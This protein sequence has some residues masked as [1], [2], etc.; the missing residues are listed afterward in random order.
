MA[1][2]RPDKSKRHEVGQEEQ[3]EQ[4]HMAV[5][6]TALSASISVAVKQA[7]V[8]ALGEKT[9]T[10]QST[11]PASATEQSVV[12][13]VVNVS[14]AGITQEKKANDTPQLMK[15]CEIVRDIAAKPGDWLY[16]DEQFRFIRQSAP[17]QYP[18]DAIHWELWLKA[19]TNFRPK[20]QFP[21]D[22]GPMRF[23]SQS[24][25]KGTCWRFHAGKVCNGCRFEHVCFKCG[26]KHP[27][28]QCALSQQKGSPVKANISNIAPQ[29]S[30]T[31]KGGSA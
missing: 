22:K 12:D 17:E 15:Y 6:L 16:Y 19:V 1:E 9:Q 3:Q 29:A 31:R 25:P 11:T 26:S 18:W 20:T 13:E 21:S 27:A 14:L 28:T 5:N 8:E 10:V 7:V 23:R 30:N 24:F 2:T 4:P